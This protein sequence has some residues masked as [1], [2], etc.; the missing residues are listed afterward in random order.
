MLP[1]SLPARLVT[2]Y[3]NILGKK[4]H[5]KI[6]LNCPTPPSIQIPNTDGTITIYV[7]RFALIKCGETPEILE[8]FYYEDD[9]L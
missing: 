5:Y 3:R 8:V 2:N 1:K 4:N 6:Q 7:R 9:G